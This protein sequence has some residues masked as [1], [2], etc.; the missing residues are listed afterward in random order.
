MATIGEENTAG[1]GPQSMPF[2]L[3]N[4]NAAKNYVLQFSDDE[5]STESDSSASSYSD[6]AS[7][8]SF[9]MEQ[10]ENE[11]LTGSEG[12]SD[13]ESS[14][15]GTGS[16]IVKDSPESDKDGSRAVNSQ[17]ESSDMPVGTVRRRGEWKSGISP[18]C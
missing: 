4:K 15:S 12:Q 2:V 7:E 6:G 10:A 1:S 13:S 8:N 9:S 3:S 17:V 14:H 11:S 18:Q 16:V 5:Y